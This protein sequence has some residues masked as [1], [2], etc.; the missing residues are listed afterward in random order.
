MIGIFV[1]WFVLC[2]VESVLEM[3]IDERCAVSCAPAAGED[4]YVGYGRNDTGSGCYCSTANG[5][6]LADSIHPNPKR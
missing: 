3:G 5:W 1:V 4:R 2:L 6:V